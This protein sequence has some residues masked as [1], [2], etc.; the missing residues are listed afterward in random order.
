MFW[1][2]FVKDKN[3]WDT[4]RIFDRVLEETPKL[5]TKTT[6]LCSQWYERGTL[7]ITNQIKYK[8]Y[9]LAGQ[10]YLKVL[11]GTYFGNSKYRCE[12]KT[13]QSYYILFLSSCMLATENR[14]SVDLGNKTSNSNVSQ[15]TYWYTTP[16]MRLL[17]YQNFALDQKWDGSLKTNDQI[18]GYN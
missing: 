2:A 7:C 6:K 5:W 12:F 3:W 13:F 1:K 4:W 9:I 17:F 15:S 16:S 11:A 8:L 18:N 10:I 14:K